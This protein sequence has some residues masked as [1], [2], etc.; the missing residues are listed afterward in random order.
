MLGIV[1]LAAAIAGHLFTD[2]S[3]PHR[4]LLLVAAAM[5]LVPTELPFVD[6]VGLVLLAV[7]AALNWRRRRGG[8]I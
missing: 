5:L 3:G 6:L 1:P 8:Q 7:V 4:G 2:L